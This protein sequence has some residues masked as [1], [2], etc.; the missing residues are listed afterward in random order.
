[1]GLSDQ[2]L[3]EMIELRNEMRQM[4]RLLQMSNPRQDPPPPP[5]P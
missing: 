4:N 5:Q 1:M 3:A 2:E